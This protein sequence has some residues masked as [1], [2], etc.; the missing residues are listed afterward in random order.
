MTYKH[1]PLIEI[2]QF[3]IWTSLASYLTIVTILVINIRNG[4]YNGKVE[5]TD[6]DYDTH[7]QKEILQN[8]GPC[9]FCD[10]VR[11]VEPSEPKIVTT[12]NDSKNSSLLNMSVTLFDPNMKPM[13][14]GV[15]APKAPCSPGSPHRKTTTKKGQPE[16]SG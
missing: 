14:D 6:R 7:Q 16:D 11:S 9:Q 2:V 12:F 5:K 8:Q 1:L 10:L 15:I 13:H 4:V 3:I